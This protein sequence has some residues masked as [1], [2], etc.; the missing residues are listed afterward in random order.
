MLKA[1]CNATQ[2]IPVLFSA[3]PNSI[4]SLPQLNTVC[5]NLALPWQDFNV[6]S[7]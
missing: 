1:D 4:F 5:A 2:M 7:G 3:N 6:I